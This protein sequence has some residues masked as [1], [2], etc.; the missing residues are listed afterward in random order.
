MEVRMQYDAKCRVQLCKLSFEAIFGAT[1]FIS[2]FLEVFCGI[3][4]FSADVRRTSNDKVA[5][6]CLNSDHESMLLKKKNLGHFHS[7]N[8][9]AVTNF[10]RRHRKTKLDQI[11]VAF[12][13]AFSFMHK[14]LICMCNFLAACMQMTCSEQKNK[15]PYL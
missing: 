9:I 6:T 10:I 5:L 2:T 7:V 13:R 14:C 15:L 4:N 12:N 3:R 1:E 8:G 11:V